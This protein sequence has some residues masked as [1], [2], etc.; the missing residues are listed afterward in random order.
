[1]TDEKECLVKEIYKFV[2]GLSPHIS[3]DVFN[4]GENLY[5]LKN[6]K[7]YSLIKSLLINRTNF[8]VIPSYIELP[9]SKYSNKRKRNKKLTKN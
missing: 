9:C 5:S 8:A 2:N 7:I 3:S 1:M 4:M 6:F